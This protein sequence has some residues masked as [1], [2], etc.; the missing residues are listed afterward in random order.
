MRINIFIFRKKKK[1]AAGQ[2]AWR[3]IFS[4]GTKQN[5]KRRDQLEMSPKQGKYTTRRCPVGG[6]VW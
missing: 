4:R 6:K 3:S 5:W 2:G 1:G